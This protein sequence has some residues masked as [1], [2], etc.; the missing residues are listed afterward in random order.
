MD[1]EA[2]VVGE[3]AFDEVGV[4]CVSLVGITRLVFSK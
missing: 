2:D 4:G 1:G 3:D